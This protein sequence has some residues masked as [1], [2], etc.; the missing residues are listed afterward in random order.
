MKPLSRRYAREFGAAMLAYVVFLLVAA[1]ALG[2]V[3]PV[4][5]RTALA[6]LP[7]AAVVLA[8]RAVLRFVRD[9]DELQRRIHL[10]AFSL[11][12]LVLCVGCFGLGMLSRAG[13]LAFDA[14]L[15]LLLVL[16][17]Y[18]LLHGAFAAVA[19]YRYR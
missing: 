16:P 4:W 6:M 14:T 7:V 5:A 13:V 8:A 18:S 2:R 11:G 19:T 12:A 9:S 15:V 10:E 3:E 1:W 17:V